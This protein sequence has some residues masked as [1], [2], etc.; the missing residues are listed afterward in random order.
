MDK[1]NLLIVDDHH[2]ILSSLADIA[3]K[4]VFVNDIITVTNGIDALQKL[5]EFQIDILITDVV[6]PGIDGIELSKMVRRL[7][8]SIKILVVTQYLNTTVFKK[9]LKQNVEAIVLKTNGRNEIEKA[10]TNVVYNKSYYCDE[11]SLI[12]FNGLKNRSINVI[13]TLL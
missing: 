12:V 2:L 10:L 9:L 1:K 3:K 6:M 7:Y 11:I 13:K 4:Q 5:K 8:P